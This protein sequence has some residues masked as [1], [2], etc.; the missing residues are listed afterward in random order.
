[1][2][3]GPFSAIFV[4][5]FDGYG[6]DDNY[7]LHTILPYSEYFHHFKYG[8]ITFVHDNP[9]G[10]IRS[11]TC[12]SILDNIKYY[13][14]SMVIGVMCHIVQ[15]REW[16]IKKRCK[17]YI[18]IAFCYF[19]WKCLIYHPLFTRWPLGNI[20][21]VLN[22]LIDLVNCLVNSCW[23]KILLIISQCVRLDYILSN[24]IF[25]WKYLMDFGRLFLCVH[26]HLLY[27]HLNIFVHIL[28]YQKNYTFLVWMVSFVTFHKMLFYKGVTMWGGELLKSAKWKQELK[29]NI[30][31]FE[32]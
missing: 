1:M 25:L 6:G 32:Y 12:N 13:T 19:F 23:R 26:L 27:V 22:P 20:F 8:V 15:M 29:C 31:F 17:L 7:L 30:F 16:Q 10:R 14:N 28:I 11:V 24:L 18:I 21:Y 9:F 4:K 3:N 5:S 2:F